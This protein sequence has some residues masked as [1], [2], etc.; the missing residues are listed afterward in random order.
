MRLQ[1]DARPL[2]RVKVKVTQTTPL[3]VDLRGSGGSLAMNPAGYTF[4]VGEAALALDDGT[5]K[6]LVFP[7]R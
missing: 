7:I 4:T 1:D 5:S 2:R 6:P 3:K